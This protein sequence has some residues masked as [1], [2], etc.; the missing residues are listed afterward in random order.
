[1][2]SILVVFPLLSLIVNN[3][4]F[5]LASFF[6][7]LLARSLCNCYS[8]FNTLIHSNYRLRFSSSFAPFSLFFFRL[9][10]FSRSS[11]FLFVSLK[12]LIF[13]PVSLSAADIFLLFSQTSLIFLLTYC[14]LFAFS[15]SLICFRLIN[16]CVHSQSIYTFFSHISIVSISLLNAFYFS[17]SLHLF[18]TLFIACLPL[19]LLKAIHIN[20][21]LSTL[22]LTFLFTCNIPLLKMSILHSS[23]MIHYLGVPI[24]GLFLILFLI[25][26]FFFY[27][28]YSVS[29]FPSHLSF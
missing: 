19:F 12:F 9:I 24:T 22:A 20:S 16:A 18:N 23:L 3:I 7:I 11:I 25:L 21:F 14:T 28:F 1:M 10:V 17:F 27:Q 8:L 13:L 15:L 29:S 4:S 26:F 5:L 6:S 2:H